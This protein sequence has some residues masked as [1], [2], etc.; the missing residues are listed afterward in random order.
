MSEQ[1]HISVGKLSGVFGIKG[2]VKVFSFTD[3]REN[4]LTY[5]PW[6]LKKGDDTKTVNVVD[7]Q[8]QGK[9]IVAQLTG[10]DDRDQAASLMGWDIFITQDQLPK[11]AKG[12]Y[13]WSD[14]IGL[15]VETIDGVQL[16]VVDSLLE[17][18][19]NDVVIVQGERERVIPFLQG[20]TI[21]NV[22]LNAGKI[23]VDWDP[24]F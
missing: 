5:S 15:N 19:A 16:G 9:T 13:Y 14:L 3:P 6:L 4:I 10:V 21:I 7:G 8:L 24:E 18:G 2:W 12:E 17:T 23:V 22:D 20:Q 1:Q 11:A